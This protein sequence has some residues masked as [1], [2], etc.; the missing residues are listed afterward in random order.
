MGEVIAVDCGHEKFQKFVPHSVLLVESDVWQAVVN[1]SFEHR[2]L[3][4][5]A[6]RQLVNRGIRLQLLMIT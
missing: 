6:G 3:Q 1:E 5:E 4:V 2:D